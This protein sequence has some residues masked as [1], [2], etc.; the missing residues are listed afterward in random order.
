M[1][2]AIPLA[3]YAAQHR[4]MIA[5]ITTSAVAGALEDPACIVV[6]VRAMAA[7][8][9]WPLHGEARGGHLPGAV[10][11]PLEW[12]TMVHGTALRRLLASKGITPHRTI[13]VY[14]GLRDRSVAMAHG[15]RRLGYP[16]VLTYDAG[17][18]VWA[19]ETCRPLAH[20]AH[21]PQLVHPAW[22]DQLV[23]G[24][25]PAT[26][27]GHGGV[28]C[29]VGWANAAVYQAG[30][31]PGARYLALEAYEQPPVWTRV[32]DT[33]LEARL[34]VAGIRHD[35]TVVLYGRDTT[36]AARA[37][38]LL[39]YAGVDDVRVLDGGVRAWCAAGYPLVTTTPCPAPERDFGAPLPGHP[40]YLLAT[41]DVHALLAERDAVLVSVRSWAEQRGATSGYPY[42][43]PTGRI[44]G[45]VWGHAGSAPG[46]MDHYRNVD[47]TMRSYQDL[48]AQWHAWGITPAKRIA[49]Y[50]GTSWRASEAF[51]YAS[52]MGWATIAVYDGGW[53]AWVQQPTNP[54]AVDTPGVSLERVHR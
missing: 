14:D 7:F 11:F 53:W 17:V 51:F 19:A 49:F 48:A 3:R 2:D 35:T 24:Q 34:R 26:Y 12:T 29:E 30:H 43:Q 40:E 18:A 44:A 54:L 36:A 15:L 39:M 37:A 5:T 20:L 47:N 23:R 6:D 9:G 33:A 31:I 52:L 28:V 25:S 27:P 16:R 46:R 8:N 4:R 1:E 13:V 22:V 41:E 21:Y 32:S 38:V 50:C 42:I 45:D 10:A